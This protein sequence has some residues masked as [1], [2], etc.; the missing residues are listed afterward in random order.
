M[1]TDSTERG[2]GGLGEPATTPHGSRNGFASSS[3]ASVHDDDTVVDDDASTRS[4][5][6]KSTPKASCAAA[7]IHETASRSWHPIAPR[8][9]EETGQDK[10]G[11]S[12]PI[13]DDVSDIEHNVTKEPVEGQP[14]AVTKLNDTT[15]LEQTA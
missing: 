9:V 14:E 2:R 3:C 15:L 1:E 7:A 5:S 4:Q 6:T 13:V 11:N 10:P 8:E 12:P